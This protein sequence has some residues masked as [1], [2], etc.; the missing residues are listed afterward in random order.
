MGRWA[1]AEE[2]P[3]GN[4]NMMHGALREQ[5]PEALRDSKSQEYAD[6]SGREPQAEH[7]RPWGSEGLPLT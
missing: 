7:V 5:E 1:L 2:Q 4:G 6:W 3:W